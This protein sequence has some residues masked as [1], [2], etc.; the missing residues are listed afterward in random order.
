VLIAQLGYLLITQQ[1]LA[2]CSCAGVVAVSLNTRWLERELAAALADS[3]AAA[4][5]SL[6][7]KWDSFLLELAAP[8]AAALHTVLLLPT[9][10]AH[11]PEEVLL[12]QRSTAQA[13][14]AIAAADAAALQ[15][16][17]C[18]MYTSG[19]TGRPKGVLLTDEGQLVQAQGKCTHVG[20]TASTVYLNVVPLF[21]VGG[22][23][24]ALGVTLAGGTHVFMPR[25]E[26]AAALQTVALARVSLIVVVPA[27]L[28]LLLTALEQQVSAAYFR[29]CICV[30]KL[31]YV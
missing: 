28:S 16:V 4:A 15:G 10:D 20:Y 30:C 29:S 25:F 11:M 9:D 18:I 1:V 31:S 5:I 6:D 2:A 7:A 24:S 12:S 21:H 13:A 23:S 27:M 3:G 19:T 8:V 26:A 22:L 14:A 17:C